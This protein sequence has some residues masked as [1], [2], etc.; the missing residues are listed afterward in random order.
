MK[1]R[2]IRRVKR[3]VRATLRKDPDWFLKHARGVIHIGANAGQERDLYQDYGLRVVWIEPVPEVFSSLVENIRHHPN[4]T[5][6]QYLVSDQDDTECAFHV[7]NNA[8]ASSSLL[9]FKLHKQ[10]WP[11]VSYNRTITL[12][13]ITL[14][15][16]LQRECIDLREYDALVLDTQGS[17]LRVLQGAAPILQ[18]FRFIKTE[19]PDFESYADC[20]QIKDIDAFVSQYGFQEI[21]RHSYPGPAEIGNYYDVVY[22]RK[23]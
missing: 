2:A 15:S 12:R 18:S 9:E 20:C 11:E 5:A 13:S 1:N 7:A 16:L 8:G 10:I 21:S 19:V 23:C 3:W 22:R 4:Q 14:G 17:E 6:F